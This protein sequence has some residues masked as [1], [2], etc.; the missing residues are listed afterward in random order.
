MAVDVV[1]GEGRCICGRLNDF[2]VRNE[3]CLNQS[4]EAVT[5]TEDEVFLFKVRCD[6]VGDSFFADYV[7][8]EFS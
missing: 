8:D 5:D 2:S 6:C 1:E 3:A 4:L 7:C